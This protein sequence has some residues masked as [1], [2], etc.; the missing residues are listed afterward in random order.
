MI[1][2]SDDFITFLTS[3]N[4][5]FLNR[6][7]L[8][9][10]E[11]GLKDM[12]AGGAVVEIGTCCGLSLNAINHIARKHGRAEPIYVCD[13]WPFPPENI[14]GSDIHKHEYRAFVIETFKRNV[15]FFSRQNTPRPYEMSA[16][17]FFAA[18]RDG[19][20]SA[21]MFGNVHRLG[22]PLS[23]AHIDGWHAYEAVASDF[24]NVDRHLHVGGFIVFDD[25]GDDM[26]FEGV[27]QVVRETLATGRYEVV[28]KNP[29]YLV[30]K[31]R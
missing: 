17:D 4:A 19:A 13:P 26:I 27:K 14:R 9:L 5:G 29:N 6:G 21:D 31:L 10:F 1:D 12:P 30:R 7:S 2:A 20:T 24:A 8:H 28:A 23:F 11:L 3:V 25:S 16:D 15:S 18:W 22:G